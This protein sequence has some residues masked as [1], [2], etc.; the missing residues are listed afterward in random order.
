[1]F[2]VIIDKGHYPIEPG[3]SAN[4]YK[5]SDLT[6]SI[7]EKVISILRNEYKLNV[8]C[9]TG[10]LQERTTYENKNGCKCFVSIH[11]NAGGGTGFESW[12]YKK[13]GE[14]E[15]IASSINSKLQAHPLKNRGIKENQSFYVLKNTKAP[16]VLIECAFID[17][18]NDIQY[19]S[20]NI[21]SISK[22]IAD[23]IGNYLG[24]K[25]ESTSS[26]KIITIE[27]G[28]STIEIRLQ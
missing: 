23:A 1:M 15:K 27:K 13:G 9:S 6:N 14:A 4:G 24:K 21:E 28:I 25:V 16:A 22:S 2:D 5:E 18:L 26:T 3:A 19:V 8:G 7:G 10:T 11:I 12:I 17:N 20:N